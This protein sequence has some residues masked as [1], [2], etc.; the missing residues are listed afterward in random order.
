MLAGR[1]KLALLV[2]TRAGV[3]A[4]LGD[5]RRL[6]VFGRGGGFSARGGG[7][8]GGALNGDSGRDEW[9]KGWRVRCVGH[10]GPA[11]HL[12]EGDVRQVPYTQA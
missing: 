2:V 11:L 12:K 10:Y 5:S 7:G 3:G 8:R 1:A 9:E 4:S 6:W